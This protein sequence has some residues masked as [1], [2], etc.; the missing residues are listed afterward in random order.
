ME[1]IVF[2]LE[3]LLFFL[4]IGHTQNTSEQLVLPVFTAMLVGS[5][6]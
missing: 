6:R 5:F 4:R 1:C 2:I 3:I